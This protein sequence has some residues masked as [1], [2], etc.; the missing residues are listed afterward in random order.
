MS[1]DEVIGSL[2]IHELWLK[3]RES[4]EE[5]KVLL[6]KAMSKARISSKE[7]F[8]SRGRGRH[9]GRDTGRGRGRGR[10]CNQPTVED[11]EK[12]PF[13]KSVIQCYNCQK[14]GHF[15][16]ECRSTKKTGDDQAYVGETT[17]VATTSSSNTAAVTSS[18]LMAMVEEVSDLL[19]NGSEG[20][21]SDPTLWYLDTGTTNHMSGYRNFFCELDESTSGFVKFGNNSRIRIEGKG[22]I[23]MNKKNGKILCFLISSQHLQSW[24]PR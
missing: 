18:L 21:S 20:A 6:A 16:Y 17:P 5:E 12:K 14:Y 15:A 19:L 1:L 22:V 7:E 3:E 4:R 13:D 10:G 8:S 9:R 11:K 24:L 2:T 23:K